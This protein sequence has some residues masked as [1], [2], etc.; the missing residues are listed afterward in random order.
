[1]ELRLPPGKRCAAVFAFEVDGMII[2]PGMMRMAGN[3]P[4]SRIPARRNSRV[5]QPAKS[6]EATLWLNVTFAC[7]P[8]G[9]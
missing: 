6:Q 5:Q 4:L 3:G 2:W 8:L 1:M 7:F 9:S